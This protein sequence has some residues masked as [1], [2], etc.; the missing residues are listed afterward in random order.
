MEL[1]DKL[2]VYFKYKKGHN[3]FRKEIKDII[4]FEI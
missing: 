1:H 2:N 3:F 4:Y